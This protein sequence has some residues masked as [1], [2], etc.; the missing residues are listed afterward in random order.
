MS[1]LTGWNYRKSITL[2]RSSGAVTNYQMKLLVGESSGA[3]G[4]DVDCGGLCLSTFNDIRFTKSD[5]TTLLD[6]WIESITGTTPNQL[7]TIWIEFDSIGTSDTTFYMYYGKSDA[8]AASNGANTFDYFDDFLGTSLGSDWKTLGTYSVSSSVCTITGRAAADSNIESKTNF[9]TN[10]ALRAKIKTGHYNDSTRRE[11]AGFQ[12]NSGTYAAAMTI[13]ANASLAQKHFS[14]SGAG[15]ES[16]SNITGGISAGSY[17]V[18]DIIRNGS[19][20]VIYRQDNTNQVTISTTVSTEDL[21]LRFIAGTQTDAKLYIDWL[22]IRKYQA[23]EPAWGSWGS[24][25]ELIEDGVAESTT[26]T[27]AMDGLTD[28]I[29]GDTAETATFTD[30]MDGY[31]SWIDGTSE[32][33]TLTDE[34]TADVLKESTSETVTLTDEM[35]GQSM[36]DGISET[37][38]ITDLMERTYEAGSNTAETATFSDLMECLH[39]VDGINET[40]TFLEY[41][42]GALQNPHRR[43]QMLWNIQNKHISLKFD[44]NQAGRGVHLVDC[45]IRCGRIRRE[46]STRFVHMGQHIKLKFQHNV[47]GEAFSVGTLSMQV[48]RVNNPSAAPRDVQSVRFTHQGSHM[49]LK[50]RHNE[51]GKTILLKSLAMTCN[52]TNNPP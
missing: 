48:N 2:S 22:L 34:M 27:D 14:R 23:T 31:G 3:T 11:F 45:A 19:T 28:T 47:A 15:A 20:S 41:G 46:D 12:I 18:W 38:T 33:S 16:T 26:F 10:K 8:T 51:A 30:A 44:H 5:G 13:P 40:I 49:Q 6:Y 42:T 24:E 37:A 7:A 1:W 17:A 29:Y 35:T 36:T 4:E 25:E 21:P 43:K 52:R 39:L 50:F 32:M 9:S